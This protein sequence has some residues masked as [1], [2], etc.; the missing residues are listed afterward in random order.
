MLPVPVW[1]PNL[2]PRSNARPLTI[3][4]PRGCSVRYPPMTEAGQEAAEVLDLAGQVR[5]PTVAGLPDGYTYG[6]TRYADVILDQAFPDRFKDIQ[7]ALSRFRPTLD[8][9]RAGGG[10]RTVFVRRFDDSLSSV[11]DDGQ[12]VWGSTNITIEKRIGFDGDAHPVSKV[13]GHEID[14]FGVGSL[15]RPF[16]GIA[17]EMEW[18][19]KDPFFDRDLINFQALH[20][21]GAVAVGVIVTR[22]PELQYLISGV[23]RSRDGRFKYGSSS[24]HWD[25]LI[26]RVNLGGGGECP[27]FL[28]GIE[29][30]RIE[31]IR[32]A[33]EVRAMLDEAA[34]LKARW[35]KKGY[36]KWRD[37][38]PVYDDLRREA[39]DL[40][41]LAE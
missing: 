4:G 23:I 28:I 29:P 3:A 33:Y 12:M 37:A 36:A 21:E 19:N 2:H 41:P 9:L 8:E 39:L 22:G 11:L 27:L 24:T 17:V 26:P 38:K 30:G 15:A 13:R 35:R 34:E 31:G 14:M 32:L 10:G 25:K 16:P 18:N 40:M 7:D 5:L 6:V 1:D 20:H